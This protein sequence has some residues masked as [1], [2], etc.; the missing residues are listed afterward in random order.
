MGSPIVFISHFD[1]K[2]G[3]ADPIRQMAA[4]VF[5]QIQAAK[6]RPR[7][8]AGY[9]N[10]SATRLS[11]VHLFADA[12]A[13]DAH[14]EGSEQRSRAAYEVIVPRAWEIYG[15]PSPDAVAMLRAEAS[16]A[17]VPLT[18]EPMSVGGF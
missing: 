4:G 15:T 5:A 12:D 14:N 18:L 17:G 9:L 7:A 2:E 6:P 8:F 11:F 16:E 10:E 1:V 13:M 3:G